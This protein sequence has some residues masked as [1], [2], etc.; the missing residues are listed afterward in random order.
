M[1]STPDGVPVTS[2]RRAPVLSRSRLSIVLAA[3][4]PV[5]ATTLLT[6]PA[7]GAPG[8]PSTTGAGVTA[9]VRAPLP[10]TVPDLVRQRVTA[11]QRVA[12]PDDRLTPGQAK[13]LSDP[14]LSVSGNTSLDLEIHAL[15]PLQGRERADLVRLG[16]RV[17]DGSDSWV[18]PAGTRLP[19]VGLLRALVPAD[20]VEQVGALPWVA[21]VRPTETSPPDVGAFESEGV[22]L[23]RA[24]DAQA[25]GIDGSGVDVGVISDGVSNVAAAQGLGELPGTV[26]V[27]NAGSGD[28]GTAMLEIVHDMAP[29]ADLLFHGTGGGVAAHV[30]AQNALAA[31]GADVI[32]EDI[33][34]DGE[35]AFQKGLAAS[36]AESLAAAGVWMS[37][38]SGNLAQRHAPRVV[39][40][41][42]GTT[43]DGNAAGGNFG[44]CANVPDNTVSFGGGDTTF[45]TTLA[46][47]ATISV[48]LQWSE[49][50]AIFP[51]AGAGGFTNLNLYVLNAAGTDCLAQSTSV[52]GGGVGDTI[53]QASWTNGGA[54]AVTVKL[55]VDVQGASGAVAVPTIDLRFRGANAVDTAARA[56]SLNPDS[57]YTDDATSAGAAFAFGSQDPTTVQ[58]ENFSGG[59][60]V[61]LLSTTVCSTSYPCPAP[62]QPAGANV[63]VAGGPGRTAIAPTHTGADGVSVSGVGGFGSGSCPA[64]TQGDCLFFGTSAATPSAAG[65]AA[66]VLSSAG[67]SGSLTP[68][69]LTA[70][71]A[72]NAVDRTDSGG[73]AG[74]DNVWG[75]GVLDAFSAAYDR[76]DLG[77]TQDCLPNGPA[78]AGALHTCTVTVTND[79]PS[80]AR[81]VTV[82]DAIT[83]TGAFT[84]SS[85][86]TGCTAPAG[87][88]VAAASVT[89]ALGDLASGASIVAQVRVSAAEPQ[90]VNAVATAS[91]GTVDP[92]PSDNTASDTLTIVGV[93]DLSLS[94][95]APTDATAGTTIQW[96][97][98]VQNDG[99]STARDVQVSDVVPAQVSGVS[100]SGSNGASCV[101]GV[102]GDSTQ[103]A[104]CSFGNVGDG[105]DRT[106]TVSAT[107]NPAFV[108]LL[109]N[110]AT[111]ISSTSD[112]DDSDNSATASTTVAASADVTATL[113]DDP[114]PVSAGRTL[115]YTARVDNDG[116]SRATGVDLVVELPA[117]VTVDDVTVTAGSALCAV[118]TPPTNEVRCDVGGLAPGAF[119]LVLVSTQ[120]DAS[121]PAGPI[122]ATATATADTPDPDLLNNIATEQ[123]TVATSADMRMALTADADVYKPSST[124]VYTAF[125][126]GG[127]AVSGLTLTCPR[128]TV[129]A[130]D[131]TSF[132]VYLTVKGKKGVVA[133][134]ATVSSTT[135]DPGAVANNTATRSVKI[136]K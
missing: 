94:K 57:N 59:G 110:D 5:L 95:S 103:P 73:A 56:G 102:P 18:R 126:N 130:G 82:Q 124:V 42:T 62:P 84:V 108:G 135:S 11:V 41:G 3:V 48:T 17:L 50:R 45:D 23:H 106:M 116:P 8:V 79:G 115:D 37:S 7:S 43:P 16:A 114:D 34:F 96:T 27:L 98:T 88:Q 77:V 54:A 105:A 65:V 100:V 28:E 111:V 113:L 109:S 64:T 99:P 92:D 2:G 22:P 32:T 69:Q 36:N 15:R 90:D 89:C 128:G 123:T 74:P 93:A 117:E 78:D 86:T 112:P 134:T 127:C 46:A 104:I 60:P 61:Q 21:A 122:T 81:A 49:P 72:A 40:N 68:A 121:A 118:V 132:Q 14:L 9:Q 97:T 12:G 19:R 24:D 26:S 31:A 136:G 20:A 39:A 125:D 4:T 55:A 35:P 75:A 91:A 107:I 52:Q 120:V 119:A 131:A 25:A 66:L 30:T 53:E 29:A 10:S 70:I 38:S 1:A 63:S 85:P 71:L 44:A 13:R 33:P 58:V 47:A 129:E 6:A 67:G 101:V 80:V 51:T 87:P 133:A 76:A 83:S